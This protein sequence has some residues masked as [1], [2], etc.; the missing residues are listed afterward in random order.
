MHVLYTKFTHLFLIALVH[1]FNVWRIGSSKSD[2][3]SSAVCT[4]E[5]IRSGRIG[6]Y[7]SA[8]GVEVG[9]QWRSWVL[10]EKALQHIY[11]H[12]TFRVPTH[13]TTLRTTAT[14]TS[15]CPLLHM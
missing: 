6:F 7:P 2:F 10:L 11:V 3:Y 13:L 5:T 12:D 14:T 1:G 4:L 8:E 9:T 15:N